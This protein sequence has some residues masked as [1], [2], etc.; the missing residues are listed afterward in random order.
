MNR[1][2]LKGLLNAGV[3]TPSQIICST[4][5]PETIKDLSEE[6]ADIKITN[7]NKIPATCDHIIIGVRPSEMVLALKEISPVINKASHIISIAAGISIE[8]L[9][10]ELPCQI[11]HILPSV[12]IS[13]CS[14]VTLIAHSQSVSEENIRWTDESFNKVGTAVTIDEAH[15]EIG[16]D[17][18]SCSPAFFAVIVHELSKSAMKHGFS[19][20]L[21]TKL[22][23]AAFAGTG[24][25]LS[26]GYSIEE[27]PKLVA[28]PNGITEKGL[29]VLN[30]EMP[31]VWEKVIGMTSKEHDEIKGKD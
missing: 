29:K 12:P 11:T 9:E 6:Y 7:E 17:L 22:A 8:S 14:G 15:F 13:V 5:R 25:M 30:E 2:I 24:K 23:T 20:E 1:I 26:N 18:M 4:R 28:T 19:E 3:L 27:I 31:V 10:K 16:S 21:A